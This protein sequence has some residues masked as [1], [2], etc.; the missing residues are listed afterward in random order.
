LVIKQAIIPGIVFEE[1]GIMYFGPF[2]G[3][4]IPLLVD[5][6]KKVK[7]LSGPR[8]VH[9]ITK[10]ER[11]LILQKRNQMFIIHLLHS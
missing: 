7:D 3:H 9:V 10:R 6:L 2:D 5:V 8:I 11:E 4:N 1:L